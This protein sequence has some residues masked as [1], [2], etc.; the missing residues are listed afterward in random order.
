MKNKQTFKDLQIGEVFDWISPEY[1][2]FFE[3]CR[4]TGT[5]GYVAVLPSGEANPRYGRMQVGSL[6]AK[7]Y[8]VGRDIQA[9]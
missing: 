3:P 2:S 5:R 6:S 7:V 1:A 4:K 8:H 9:S